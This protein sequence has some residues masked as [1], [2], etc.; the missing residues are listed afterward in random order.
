MLTFTTIVTTM[1]PNKTYFTSDL[2]FGHANILKYTNRPYAN[3]EEMNESLILNWN[4]AVPKDGVV[5]SLGD[6]A[7]CGID[8]IVSILEQLH[9]TIYMIGGN[10]DRQIWKN[11]NKLLSSGLVEEITPY[12]EVNVG[13]Q[14]ICLFHYG[15]RVWNRSHHGSWMLF[16]HSHGSLPAYGKSVDVGVDAADILGEPALRPYSFNEVKRFMD[17]REIAVGDGH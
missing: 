2:H 11:A 5:F 7:F 12:K 14:M 15:C 6:F 13:G 16:G 3:V 17:S 1:N 4:D 10:H 9:G 8:A